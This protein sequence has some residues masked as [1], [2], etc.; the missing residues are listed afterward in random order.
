MIRLALAAAIFATPVFAAET[1]EQSCEYQAQVVA[2]IQQARL[3]KVKERNVPE[4]LAATNPTW[5]ENYNNAIPL[6]AP[7]VYE[8]KMKVIR[9]EDL[10]A[11]WTELCL[12]Q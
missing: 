8:Q 3:D 2:A 4:A 6:I 9:E 5:P 10:S 7:W 11:A 12:Q 1:K